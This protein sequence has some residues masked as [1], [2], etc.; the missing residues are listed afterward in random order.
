M[1][2]RPAK[3]R[4]NRDPTRSD[5]RV[6]PTRGQLWPHLIAGSAGPSLV[7]GYRLQRPR[8]S[9]WGH[10]HVYNTPSPE[11]SSAFI[12]SGALTLSS[13]VR[14]LGVVIDSELSMTARVNNLVKVRSFHLRQLRL[15]LNESFAFSCWSSST[16]PSFSIYSFF[17]ATNAS[18]VSSGVVTVLS[19]NRVLLENQYLHSE[20]CTFHH[21]SFSSIL[22]SSC[23][24]VSPG[25]F[26]SN[27]WPF[28]PITGPPFYC[29]RRSRLNLSML[30]LLIIGGVEVNPGP[31]PSN[32]LTTYSTA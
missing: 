29:R 4:Q 32:N 9:G 27:R 7:P 18:I 12:I 8:S 14:N 6:H 20:T 21:I 19:P 11:I 22:I 10:A 25:L 5:P 24:H 23:F 17:L 3:I 16:S 2:T 31:S 1:L 26:S 28:F 30:L 13:H 15:N